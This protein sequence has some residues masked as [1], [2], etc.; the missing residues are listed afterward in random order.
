MSLKRE[1]DLKDRPSLKTLKRPDMVSFGTVVSFS[2]QIC[3]ELVYGVL[4][5]PLTLSVVVDCVLGGWFYMVLR[6]DK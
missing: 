3:L 1:G 6:C 2:L 5:L 4:T